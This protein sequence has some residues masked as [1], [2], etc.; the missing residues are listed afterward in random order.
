M[1]TS[2]SLGDGGDPHVP[3]KAEFGTPTNTAANA[4]HT[5]ESRSGNW[6]LPSSSVETGMS[7]VRCFTMYS[8]CMVD[9]RN[10]LVAH[11]GLL[12]ATASI[13]VPGETI[14]TSTVTDTPATL[15]LKRLG[16]FNRS[17]TRNGAN[18]GYDVPADL[19]YANSL[20]LFTRSGG[21]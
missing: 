5:Y 9:S 6:A 2:E 1:Q 7:E 18:I 10:R 13:V 16:H 20:D 12:T 17:I 8:G 21:W 14:A 3:I 11:F 19:T 4:P 15:V